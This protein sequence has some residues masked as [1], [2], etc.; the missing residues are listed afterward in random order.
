MWEQLALAALAQH[1]WAD[2]QV[3]CTV[4]FDPEGEGKQIA[5]ALDI[6]QYQLKGISLLPRADGGAYPQMPYEAITKEQYDEMIGDISTLKF[7][8]ITGEEI[9]IERFC[10]G[11]VCMMEPPTPAQDGS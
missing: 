5:T 2:N 9:N 10:D 4:T 1:Y 11:D 6:Y 3:S 8:R 7:G